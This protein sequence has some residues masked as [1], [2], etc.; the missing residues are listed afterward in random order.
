MSRSGPLDGIRVIEFGNLVAAPYCGMLLADLGAEVTKV[1]PLNGDLARAIGPFINGHSAFFMSVNRGK[2]S[3]AA[4]TKS[5]EVAAALRRLVLEADVL[6]HNLR[7]GAMERM[8]LAHVELMAES[9]R[10]VFAAISAFGTTGPSSQRAGID[11]IFQGESGMMSISGGE[12]EP[13]H[14]TATTIADFVAGTNAAT[15]ICAALVGRSSGGSGRLVE[16]SLRDGLIAVQA[17][18]NAQFFAT[19]RPPPRTGTASPVTAPN[20]TFRTSDGYVNLAVVSDRHFLEVC[21]LLELGQIAEDDRYAHNDSRVENRQ[22]LTEVMESVLTRRSTDHWIEVFV[23]AGLAAGRLLDLSAVF[24]DP[25]AIHNEMVVE[26][27][28]QAA[29]TIKVTGSPLRLDDEPA[30][31]A[32]APPVLGADTRSVMERAGLSEGDIDR[33]ASAGLLLIGPP[34]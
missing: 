14:K 28:H 4:D 21:R 18:W 15:A 8:G 23:G 16:V 30:R 9:P 32:S 13:P 31:A 11:L 26:M 24:D 2:A 10:L 34:D 33:L 1:E 6:V 17:G 27:E 25:Q 3:V 12:G 19:G 20:Q 7:P 22:S 5:M 29:G